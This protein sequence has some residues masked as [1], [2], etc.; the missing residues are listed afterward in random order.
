M[1]VVALDGAW[2][3]TM[4]KQINRALFFLGVTFDCQL[5]TLYAFLAGLFTSA[6]LAFLP[7]GPIVAVAASNYVPF[8]ITR[9]PIVYISDATFAAAAKLYPEMK[10][11]PRWLFRQCDHHEALTLRRATYII[12]PSKWAADSAKADYGI[13]PEKIFEL[14][15]GANITKDVVEAHYTPKRIDSRDV[16]LL[17]A[18]ADWSRKGGEKAID[19]CR[20]LQSFGADV[21]LTVIGRAPEHI[22]ELDFVDFKG[23]LRKDD[24]EELAQICD[25]FQKAHFLLLPTQADAYGIVFVEAQAFAVPPIA[26]EVGGTSSAIE[27]GATGLLFPL[28][29]SPAQF[30]EGILPYVQSPAM[31]EQ[32]SRSCRAWYLE[33]AQWSRW[34]DLVFR[35][36]RL[37]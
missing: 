24:P 4:A 25:A 32:L 15:F 34:S 13:A 30:V 27:H 17:F 28:A 26:H 7:S 8:L 18:S 1:P 29:A 16:Q 2:L 6:R 36:C 31:Y 37:G 20:A 3:S 10:S 35:L 33:S 12:L 21:H 5:T 9:R 14:P 11:L 23:F 22:R 19:V